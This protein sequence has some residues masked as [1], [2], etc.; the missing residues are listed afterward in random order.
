M[1][2]PVSLREA[3]RR[4]GLNSH[5]VKGMAEAIGIHLDEAPPSLLMSSDDFRRLQERHMRIQE[6]KR[7]LQAASA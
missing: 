7:S 1:K 6:E 5:Y 3:G 2:G 4:L